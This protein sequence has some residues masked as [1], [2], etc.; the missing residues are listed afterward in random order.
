MAH[1]PEVENTPEVVS[2]SEEILVP[3]DTGLNNHEISINYMHD[4]KLWDR[5]KSII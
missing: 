4:M 2:S 1:A 5:S 3:K